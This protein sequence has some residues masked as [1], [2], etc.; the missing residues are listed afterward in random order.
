MV[1]P[2]HGWGREGEAGAEGEEGKDEADEEEE[3]EEEGEGEEECSGRRGKGCDVGR[4]I[5]GEGA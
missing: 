5:P 1:L 4:R 2:P 3:E